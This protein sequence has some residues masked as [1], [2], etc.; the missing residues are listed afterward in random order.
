MREL[1]RAVILNLA[2]DF[3]YKIHS[4]TTF[5]EIALERKLKVYEHLHAYGMVLILS[6]SLSLSL[7]NFFFTDPVVTLA[8]LKH[9][10][11]DGPFGG[12][13]NDTITEPY[14]GTI[15]V[16]GDNV[17]RA[18]ETP[19]ISQSGNPFVRYD[20]PVP[21]LAVPRET[22]F[23]FLL[24]FPFFR[25]LFADCTA[26]IH[27]LFY[28]SE[29]IEM[30]RRI[31]SGAHYRIQ[32]F[33]IT[34][35]TDG[36]VTMTYINLRTKI[37]C[38]E[39]VPETCSGEIS[40]EQVD[41]K[42]AETKGWVAQMVNYHVV[43]ITCATCK[44]DFRVDG[45]LCQKP[46]CS[47]SAGKGKVLP[48]KSLVINLHVQ[49]AQTG[50]TLAPIT[51][52][53]FILKKDVLELHL[54]RFYGDTDVKSTNG[55]IGAFIRGNTVTKV[56]QATFTKIVKCWCRY[57]MEKQKSYSP[58]GLK[59]TYNPKLYGQDAKGSGGGFYMTTLDFDNYDRNEIDARRD[60]IQAR[61]E[62]LEYNEL[63]A[64]AN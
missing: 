53:T 47:Q 1:R 58:T 55:P 17:D 29:N 20:N 39:K 3:V 42:Y 22:L 45:T 35:K 15:E 57:V 31:V 46:D 4:E 13:T 54:R 5:Y 9:F 50:R 21:M 8:N 48:D 2:P 24:S 40:N 49:E 56:T 41:K 59:I 6:L 61:E 28:G 36:S 38:L 30:A 60:Y 25:V 63:Y 26:R 37:E 19:T 34:A 64:I 51:S 11:D 10:L 43:K 16:V 12:K 52:S 14:P 7:Y 18:F 23:F 32:H 62:L 44:C 27:M 33:N